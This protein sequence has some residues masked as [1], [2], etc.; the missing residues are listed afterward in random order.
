MGSA[1]TFQLNFFSSTNFETNKIFQRKRSVQKTIRFENLKLGAPNLNT[2]SVRE[3][4]KPIGF[5]STELFFDPV[6][7]SS[8]FLVE[9]LCPGGFS[10]V[11]G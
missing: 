11:G 3:V 6:Q 5:G 7:C 10:S 9:L 8:V 1:L 2:R 4:L